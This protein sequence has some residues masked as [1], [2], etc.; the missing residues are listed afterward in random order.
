MTTTITTRTAEEYARTRTSLRRGLSVTRAKTTTS[1]PLPKPPIPIPIPETGARKKDRPGTQPIEVIF[2]GQGGD[3]ELAPRLVSASETPTSSP[4]PVTPSTPLVETISPKNSRSSLR[5]PS[6]QHSARDTGQ[7]LHHGY[8]RSLELNANHGSP[9]TA[10]SDSRNLGSR[11]D[12]ALK[13]SAADFLDRSAQDPIRDLKSLQRY[14]VRFVQPTD[15]MRG[16]QVLAQDAMFAAEVEFLS[17][18]S[19]SLSTAACCTGLVTW[20]TLDLIDSSGG[21]SCLVATRWTS[22]IV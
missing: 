14:G 18:V 13:H 9:K 11:S 10:A 12:P 15:D 17:K 1:K 22:T 3:A 2:E 4:G 16:T 8:T 21:S 20:I 7:N 6:T 5:P 19:S